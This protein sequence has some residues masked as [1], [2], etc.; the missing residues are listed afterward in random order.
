MHAALL[1]KMSVQPGAGCC[2]ESMEEREGLLGRLHGQAVS[3]SRAVVERRRVDLQRT[4]P[5]FKQEKSHK[6]L[7]R[8]IVFA[9]QKA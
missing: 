9:G 4:S 8:Y 7:W 2:C 1:V 6:E 3:R 5:E